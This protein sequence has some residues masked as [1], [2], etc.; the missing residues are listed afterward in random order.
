M[1]LEILIG[2]KVRMAL[3][4]R[5]YVAAGGQA[6]IYRKGPRGFKIYHD[7]SHVPP[8]QKLVEMSVIKSRNVVLPQSMVYGKDGAIIGYELDFLDGMV[9]LCK[10]FTRNFKVDNNIDA[11]H[12]LELVKALQSTVAEVHAGRCLVVDLNEMNVLVG[13]TWVVP[14]L[15]DMDSCQTPNFPAKAIMDS[16]RDRKVRNGKWTTDSDWFAW[17][18]LA[19]QL[20]VNIHPYKGG[21]PGYKPNEWQKRMEDDASVFDKGVRLP[22]VCNPL[23]S[24]PKRHLEWFRAVFQRGE[25]STPPLADSSIPVAVPNA[26][27]IMDSRGFKT[28]KVVSFDGRIVSV[29]HGFGVQYVVTENHIH[30][31]GKVF[32]PKLPKSKA[33]VVLGD[34]GDPVV[35][36]VGRAVLFTDVAG[37]PLGTIGSPNGAF[38]RNNAIYSVVAGGL[39]ETSFC[40]MGN[41]LVPRSRTVQG[42]SEAA[43]MLFDGLVVQDLLGRKWVSVPYAPGKCLN[44]PV[45]QLDGHRIIDAKGEKNV[46]VVI[47]EKAGVYTRF[48]LVFGRDWSSFKL[49]VDSD[50]QYDGI[51][52]TVLDNGMAVL[53]SSHDSVDLF[54]DPGA[55]KSIQGPPFDASMKLFSRG[56]EVF[57]IND[58]TIYSVKTT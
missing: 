8:A 17:G 35:S 25:R 19:F 50:I 14:H 52:F 18:V 51:N 57:V 2:G 6:S 30:A 40:W 12:I 47:G 32:C 23:S 22:T 20:Y 58:D 28:A 3:T 38:A 1:K 15:I 13:D 36:I 53:L 21:H 42:V 45:P 24:I 44:M 48:I 31:D 56:T 34:G 26:A 11:D 54:F 41:S 16:I 46:C 9:P 5:D 37:R 7:P 29:F 27:I 33:L 49:G 39:V 10:L 55:R 43:C 4:D